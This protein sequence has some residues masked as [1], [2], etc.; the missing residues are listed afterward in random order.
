[1]I[2]PDWPEQRELVVIGAGPAGL[3]AAT[4]AA[5]LGIDTLLLDEQ[6]LPGGQIW[7]A[8]GQSPARAPLLGED[9]QRGMQ[10]VLA[11]RASG[12]EHRPSSSVFDI[13]DQRVV[14]VADAAGGYAVHAGR[15]IIATGALERPFPIPGWTLPG[16][17][18]AGGAQSLLKSAGLVPAPL[19]SD[20]DDPSRGDFV[21]A[22]SGPLVLLLAWQ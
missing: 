20:H 11:L 10:R 13:D 2:S 17:M 8:V 16:V 3:T 18:M 1:M 9:Y 7:R 6:A 14:R 4:L 15:V 22:G 5:G 12:A 21:L 19:A